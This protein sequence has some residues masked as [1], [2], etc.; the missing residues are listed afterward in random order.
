MSMENATV[1]V[2]LHLQ[3]EFL[4]RPMKFVLARI[5]IRQLMKQ[6]IITGL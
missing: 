1:Y 2:I 6:K 3:F 5:T 4:Y